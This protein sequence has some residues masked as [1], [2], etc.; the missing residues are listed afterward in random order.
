MLKHDKID[1]SEETDV[2][3]TDISK[4]CMFCH[5][6]YLLS[7]KFSY[8]PY[9]CDG[10][11]DIVQRSKDSKNIAIVH[12][13]KIAYRIYFVCMSKHEAKKSVKKHYPI[14]KTGSINCND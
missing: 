3:K 13:K 12:I 11:Y 7:K 14:D 8:C 5:C 10:C 4:E 9:N 1:I 2:N 6:W